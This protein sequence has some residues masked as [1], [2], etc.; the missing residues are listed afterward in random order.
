MRQVG[1]RGRCY[2]ILW[3]DRRFF[4]WVEGIGL[5]P[6]KSR[7]LGELTVPDEYFADFA[8]GCI[9]GDASIVVYVDRHHSHKDLRYVYERLCV[10]LVSASRPFVDWFRT[11]LLR[12]V[13]I[14][15]SI[16][17]K[18]SRSGRPYWVFRYARRESHRLL[19][20]IYYARSIPCLARKRA[21]SEPFLRWTRT[22]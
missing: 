9:D 11:S 16:S 17:E 10:T 22:S 15:G 20:W 1:A 18:V 21:R 14:H 3:R 13:G 5:S 6:A 19:S 2:R 7:T 8:R 12:L 4:E